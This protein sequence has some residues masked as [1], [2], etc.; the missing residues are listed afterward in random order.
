MTTTTTNTTIARLPD[1][2]RERVLFK[3]ANTEQLVS[4]EHHWARRLRDAQRITGHPLGVAATTG[5]GYAN[6]FIV[7]EHST[8]RLWAISAAHVLRIRRVDPHS[9]ELGD[10][11][12]GPPVRTEG[13]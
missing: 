10:V 11:L 1:D 3:I 8:G 4:V 5:A 12:A 13:Q 7:R 2:E 6:P 9:Y